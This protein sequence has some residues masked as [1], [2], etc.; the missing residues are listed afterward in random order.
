MHDENWHPEAT[1][2][3]DEIKR[4]LEQHEAWQKYK[5]IPRGES[6]LYDKSRDALWNDSLFSDWEPAQ[7]ELVRVKEA[8]DRLEICRQVNTL[9]LAA[10]KSFTRAAERALSEKAKGLPSRYEHDGKQRVQLADNRLNAVEHLEESLPIGSDSRIVEEWNRLEH[11]R[12]GRLITDAS[13]LARIGVA[14][15]RHL[16]LEQLRK[17]PATLRQDEL[18]RQLLSIWQTSSLIVRTRSRGNLR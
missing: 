3:S 13:H 8:R 5:L 14:R 7:P 9:A 18:D 15:H 4:L 10:D 6:Q 2:T 11:F 16:L 12:G 1:L 17:L